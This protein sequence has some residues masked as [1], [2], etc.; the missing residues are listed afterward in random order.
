MHKFI[1]YPATV[2]TFEFSDEPT[3]NRG[4]IEAR[5]K[6]GLMVDFRAQFQYKLV[7][8]YLP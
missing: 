8:E 3:A 1:P 6:D 7:K 4:L 2:I 5:S